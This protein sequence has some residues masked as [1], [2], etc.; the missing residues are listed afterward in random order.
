VKK[1]TIALLGLV[2]ISFG[3]AKKEVPNIS[4]VIAYPKVLACLDKI[5]G[6]LTR[7]EV[8]VGREMKTRLGP[9]LEGT[10]IS[11][12]LPDNK[13][14]ILPDSDCNNVVGKVAFSGMDSN[15]M[16]LHLNDPERYPLPSDAMFSE[17]FRLYGKNY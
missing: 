7:I 6:K 5:P 15:Q 8:V 16:F 2:V 4:S 3:C 12:H 14:V 11:Y 13:Q 10:E 1:T 17:N 9:I